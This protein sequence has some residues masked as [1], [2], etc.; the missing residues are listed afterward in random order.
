MLKKLPSYF[1]NIVAVVV[2]ALSVFG[3]RYYLSTNDSV[4]EL[5]LQV[6]TQSLFAAKLRDESGTFQALGQWKGKLIV[7]NFWATWCPPCL[8]E[9]P[10]LARLQDKYR[11]R[12][13]VVLGISTDELD[14]IQEFS[15]EHPVSYPLFSGNL[16]AM[17]LGISL[18][19]DKG[20]LP[21][22]VVINTDGTIAKT[23]F[24]QVD[25]KL[26]EQTLLPLLSD[27]V[28]SPEKL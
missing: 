13:V 24:G 25:L 3:I 1:V 18:G 19:N 15:R 11:E 10:E 7:V 27:S 6:S 8:E 26:L 21:Y 5:P 16:E 14:K 17:E 2:I 20:V 12:N 23:Y 28:S 9:M 4:D 22:T